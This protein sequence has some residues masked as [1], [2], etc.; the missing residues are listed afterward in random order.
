MTLRCLL[1]GMTFLAAFGVA[2]AEAPRAAAPAGAKTWAERLG[3]PAGKRV[4][5]LHADDLGMCYEAN[6][7]GQ[8]ALSQGAYRSGS[9]MV[10][11]V[12]AQV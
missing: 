1:A 10:S 8:R 5:L 7:S 4:V 3:W 11:H 12:P 6:L 9:A 2:A